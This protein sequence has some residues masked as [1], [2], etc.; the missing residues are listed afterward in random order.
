MSR[1]CMRLVL[2][3]TER[4]RCSRR[5]RQSSCAGARRRTAASRSRVRVVAAAKGRRAARVQTPAVG[6]HQLHQHGH[7]SHCVRGPSAPPA[8]GCGGGVPA[9]A[10]HVQSV[11]RGV[12]IPACGG[13]DLAAAVRSL[14]H[15]MLCA[16]L[17]VCPAASSRT[18]STCYSLS[19]WSRS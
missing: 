2:A 1:G 8:R 10:A 15:A 13:E 18:P 6:A 5:G 12:A 3:L 16:P 19:G 11:D 17:S 7:C 14:C 9:A 4:G